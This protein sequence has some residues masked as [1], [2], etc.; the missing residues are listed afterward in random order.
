MTQL[1]L[2]TGLRISELCQLPFNC[3]TQDSQGDWWLR[4]NA[5]KMHEQQQKPISPDLITIIENQ[6][7]YIRKNLGMEYPFLFCAKQKSS[8]A[9][10]KRVV[11]GYFQPAPKPPYG[12]VFAKA[13]NDLAR[14]KN[15]CDVSG[16]LW[17]FQTHQFRHTVGTTQ[18]NQGV[19]QHIVQRFLGHKSP[20]MTAVYAHLHDDT[21]KR[22]FE[23]FYRTTVDA[24]GVLKQPSSSPLDVGDLQ[25]FKHNILAQALSNGT[26]A[27]PAPAQAC[28]HANAC[29][30][31][32]HFRT[33]AEFLEQHRRHLLQTE[34]FIDK[35]Q[36]NGWTR[37]V[38]M[39]C[40]IAQNLRAV[41][42][43]L[44]EEQA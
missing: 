36:A 18:I 4:Y 44:E 38:E 29:L 25:W 42:K 24:T 43:T 27:L 14:E 3:I 11:D 9:V 33:T 1:L 30:T 37:Q 21:L 15:I 2:E 8:S 34:Q 23:K 7:H 35:A 40:Q 41:I 20:N 6:Q 22:E 5:F 16:Q 13:L 39:N 17:H 10:G 28:P 32:A 31:C 19:P 12:M 26:C